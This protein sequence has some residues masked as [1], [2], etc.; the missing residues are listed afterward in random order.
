[1]AQQDARV[2]FTVDDG[3]WR[4]RNHVPFPLAST[5]TD[6]QAKLSDLEDRGL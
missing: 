2:G 1:L 6:P 5:F 4:G 3:I